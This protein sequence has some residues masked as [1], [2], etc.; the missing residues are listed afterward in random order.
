[1]TQAECGVE[2]AEQFGA[3]P[4]DPGPGAQSLNVH[5]RNAYL[6]LLRLPG[7]AR[8]SVAAAIGRTPM[9]MY[10]LGTVLLVKATTGQYGIAGIP[11]VFLEI[12]AHALANIR[13]VG[14]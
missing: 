8:F 5:S 13:P 14:P 4:A 10:G 6:S 1:M 9:A 11:A 7:A 12:V 3:G 2:A